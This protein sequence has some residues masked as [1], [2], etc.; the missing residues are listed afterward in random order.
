[1]HPMPV[2]Y[3]LRHAKS[4]WDDA[5]LADRDRPLAPRGRKAAAAIGRYLAEKGAAPGLLLCSPALRCRE[6]LEAVRALLPTAGDVVVEAP[7][8]GAGPED[9]LARLRA[10]PE[11]TASVMLVGHN[12]SMEELAAELAGPEAA[13]RLGGR[14]PT[15]ALA[16]YDVAGSWSDLGSEPAT[17]RDFVVPRDLG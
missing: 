14:F 11:T 9:L 13:P 6:T 4:N 17:L 8:Y 2:L 3:L 16:I 12:P 1:M 7:L 5:A 15:G 10:V